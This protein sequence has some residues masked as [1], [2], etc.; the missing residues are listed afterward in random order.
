MGMP[1]NLRIEQ[2]PGLG[3]RGP[4]MEASAACA[5][6]TTSTR[7]PAARKRGLNG[8]QQAVSGDAREKWAE[9]ERHPARYLLLDVSA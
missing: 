1:G 7:A 4:A 9:L 3:G 8:G 2:E 5:E 6:R